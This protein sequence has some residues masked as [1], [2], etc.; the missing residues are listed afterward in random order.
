[1]PERNGATVQPARLWMLWRQLK[2]HFPAWSFVF[3][4]F[5]TPGAWGLFGVDFT[6]GLRANRST[7][8]AFE[9][10]SQA[11]PAEF[12]ALTALAAVN[13][14]RQERVFRAVAIA[15]LT[16][17]ITLVVTWG[18]IAPDSVREAV[19]RYPSSAFVLVFGLTMGALAYFISAWRARQIID[20][21]DLFRIERGAQPYTA[22]E[23]REGD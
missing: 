13:A 14:R 9:V 17:P 6:T 4:A 19:E 5:Y 11:S 23:L 8:R 3:S 18:E 21:M 22:L 10:L 15:Y 2:R 7:A 20:V 1:M 16:V 12:D